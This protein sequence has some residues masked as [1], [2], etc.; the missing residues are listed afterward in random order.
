[1]CVLLYSLKSNISLINAKMIILRNGGT[2]ECNPLKI[3]ECEL[4]LTFVKSKS[5]QVRSRGKKSGLQGRKVVYIEVGLRE[6]ERESQG[7]S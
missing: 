2:W 4:L 1:M 3:K 7:V 5:H 6:R